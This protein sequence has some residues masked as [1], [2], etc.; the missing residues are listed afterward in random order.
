MNGEQLERLAGLIAL[1][2]EGFLKEREGARVKS[3]AREQVLALW[4]EAAQPV[5]VVINGYKV[6]VSATVRDVWDS[7][8]LKEVLSPELLER[9]RRVT[10]AVVLN[11]RPER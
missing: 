11:V 7:R 8:A 5:P 4:R 6:D 9:C 10:T 1:Y 2:N 3:V